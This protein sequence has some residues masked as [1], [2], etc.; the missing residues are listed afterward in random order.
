MKNI[1][2]IVTLIFAVFGCGNKKDKVNSWSQKDRNSFIN[3]CESMGSLIALQNEDMWNDYCICALGVAQQKWPNL[4]EADKAA[5]NLT[6]KDFEE[7]YKGCAK[8]HFDL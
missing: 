1:L 6:M 7:L 4:E 3:Q 8:Q 5:M 2:L